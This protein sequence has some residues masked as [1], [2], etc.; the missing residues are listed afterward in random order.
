[1]KRN[2]GYTGGPKAKLDRIFFKVLAADAAL[3]QMDRGELDLMIVPTSEMELK[4]NP[5]LTVVVSVPSPSVDFLAI[6]VRKEYLQDKRVRQ[7]M[8]YAIDREAVVKAIY[9][10]EAQVVNQTII[11]P[12]WMGMPI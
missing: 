9:Q 12:D 5:N 2:D 4:K 6:N 8:Q 1:M 3:A 7:A 10:G 11:G